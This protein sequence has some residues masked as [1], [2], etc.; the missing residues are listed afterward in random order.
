MNFT[1]KYS[2]TMKTLNFRFHYLTGE[3]SKT[4]IECISRF[5]NL[6]ELKLV[7]LL[8]TTEPINESI[9]LIGRKCIKLLK[10]NISFSE[11]III[12][13]Q[14][15][16][17]ISEFKAIKKLKIDLPFNTEM[18]GSV[19]YFKHC[20]QLIDLNIIYPN[21]TE[22]FFTNVNTFVPKLQSL[23][24][25]SFNRFSDS[26]INNFQSMKSI[27]KVIYYYADHCK[28][29]KSWCFGKCLSEVLSS[30]YGKDVI[31]INDKCGLINDGH[32]FYDNPYR[33]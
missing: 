12:K 32:Y 1:D 31:L 15:F 30:P 19:E 8:K 20:K 11:N 17:T 27:E 29:K 25:L 21:V 28:P 24:I 23:R 3:E 16:D 7:L 22:N 13:E 33:D 6:K 5:K 14:F 10:F 26:F 2:R 18:I 4:C 9:A